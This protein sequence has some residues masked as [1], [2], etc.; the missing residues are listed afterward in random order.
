MP[1]QT[2]NG[3]FIRHSDLRHEPRQKN[4]FLRLHMTCDYTQ[5]LREALGWEA[6]PDAA[7]SMK[8]EEEIIC[9]KMV[10]KP[11]DSRLRQRVEI[12]VNTAES[13]EVVRVNDD[14]GGTKVELRFNLLSSQADAETISGAYLRE[15]GWTPGVLKLTYS[16]QRD[17][18]SS[19]EEIKQ[20]RL[21]DAEKDEE[22]AEPDNAPSIAPAATVGRSRSRKEVN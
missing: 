10:L 20:M 8:I 4:C 11:A 3:A 17:L 18:V 9:Q 12:E 13:F 15:I 2:F 14:N 7:K 6:L 16:E 5:D 1:T 19:P 21:A 22:A